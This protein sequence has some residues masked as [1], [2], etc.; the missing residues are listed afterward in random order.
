MHALSM[1][2][3]PQDQLAYSDVSIFDGISVVKHR[4]RSGGIATF[5]GPSCHMSRS[6]NG[7]GSG[8]LRLRGVHGHGNASL[9]PVDFSVRY[10]QSDSV[11]RVQRSDGTAY[12]VMP[13][14]TTAP[15]PAFA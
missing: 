5:Y 1:G 12:Q 10:M 15:I 7:V 9:E 3:P 4:V 6:T 14:G 13:D 11:Y 2:A 8:T